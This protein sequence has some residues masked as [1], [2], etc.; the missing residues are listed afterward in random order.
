[1]LYAVRE[2]KV[3]RSSLWGPWHHVPPSPLTDMSCR[4]GLQIIHNAGGG[5][6]PNRVSWQGSVVVSHQDVFLWKTKGISPTLNGEKI[7]LRNT[8]S[9]SKPKL[10]RTGHTALHSAIPRKIKRLHLLLHL[11]LLPLHPT[12][13]LTFLTHVVYFFLLF[14]FLPHLWFLNQIRS[15]HW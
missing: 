1:M 7:K 8:F 5:P 14:P 12:A 9:I 4:T 6:A 2:H 13:G 10:K 3:N 11:G 15:S